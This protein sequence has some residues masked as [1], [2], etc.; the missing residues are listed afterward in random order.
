MLYGGAY[1]WYSKVVMILLGFLG[2]FIY[3]KSKG[4]GIIPKDLRFSLKWS[5]YVFLLFSGIGLMFILLS[6]VFGTSNFEVKPE[7]I[8]VDFVWH[9]V[10][11][12][13]SEE[14][15]FRG[16]VQSRLN[17]VFKKKYGGNPWNRI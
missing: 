4:Y 11:V 13:F 12:G 1:G 14:V 9:S 16:F 15:F 5:T 6:T 17:E 2:I 8:L 7:T 10:F 3:R